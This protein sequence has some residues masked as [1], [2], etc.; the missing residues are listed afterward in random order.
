LDPC[1]CLFP[2]L[3][4]FKLL[5]IS[6]LQRISEDFVSRYIRLLKPKKAVSLGK[7][8][9][10]PLKDS[11]DVNITSS[12]TNLQ[13]I[14]NFNKMLEN[15]NFSTILCTVFILN[16]HPINRISKAGA[17]LVNTISNARRNGFFGGNFLFRIFE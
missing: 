8:S 13:I 3:V 12:F 10:R 14:V 9:A 16:T 7:I 17:A 2:G 5:F 1:K 4:Y 15:V 6:F 11:V